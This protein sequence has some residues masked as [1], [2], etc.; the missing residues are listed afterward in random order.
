MSTVTIYDYAGGAA[1]F[2]RLV[3]Q[4]Y[5][6]VRRDPLVAPLFEHFT[7][8]HVRNV[9]IWLGEVFGGPPLYSQLHGGHGAVYAKHGGLGITAEQRARWAELMVATA[10]DVLP[11]EPK[12]QR[13]FA[14]YIEWGSRIA[15]EA[16][17]PGFI[18]GAVG[19]V[20]HWD[21]G[22]AG[23]PGAADPVDQAG[24]ATSESGKP[25]RFETEI[26]PL[27]RERDRG[28]MK[29]AFD[30][31]S[32]RDV[33]QHAEAI[34]RRLA[35]GTMPCDGAWPADQVAIFRRWVE[36]GMPE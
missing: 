29:W 12:L 20:P 36:S 6:K 28:S 2:Q 21:W 5:E 4:F 10:G 17:Q 11:P 26:R 7:D 13:R 9:A 1:A 19:D 24:S 35:S 15:R 34:L 3:E 25:S 31:W 22:P 14:E 33:K 16:S 8:E 27:F 18:L 23:P 30:L 32:Y